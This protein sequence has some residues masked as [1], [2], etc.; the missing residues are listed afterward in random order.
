[1]K[2]PV[3]WPSVSFTTLKRS[4]SRKSTA[5]VAL[6][7]PRGH[8]RLV[9]AVL[10]EAAVG[11]P[12]ER[13][14][15]RHVVDR[16]LG[17]QPL[18]DV[19]HQGGEAGHA[20]GGVHERRVVP[21]ALDVAAAARHVRERGL[22]ALARFEQLPAHRLAGPRAPRARRAAAA[23]GLADRLVGGEAEDRLGGGVPRGDASWRSHSITASGVRS[24]C[25][26]SFCAA[27]SSP[28]CA[29]RRSACSSASASLVSCSRGRARSASSL[30]SDSRARR[31]V[32][33]STSARCSRAC[34]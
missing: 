1:M 34:T 26:R 31:I 20:A 14:V 27:T 12:G 7:A 13:V 32:S 30:E 29:F 10:H 28:C 3:S 18:G 6:L 21:L 9:E 4:R 5:D 33:E 17:V 25:M 15:V 16:A 22:V 8:D 2:S 19:L 23:S 24:K 11:Q